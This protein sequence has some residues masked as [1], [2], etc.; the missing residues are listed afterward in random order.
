MTR[1][2]TQL[3][4]TFQLHTSHGPVQLVDYRGKQKV[5]MY[6]MREFNCPMCTKV[7]LH[8][9]RMHPELQAHNIQVLVLGGGDEKAAHTL[10]KRFDLPF[11]VAADPNRNIYRAYSLEKTLGLLQWNGT[12]LVDLD[13]KIVYQRVS[14]RPGGSFD[15]A[16]LKAHW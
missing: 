8:L 3:A 5:L 11:P 16:E 2:L 12:V 13:G 10:Q 6:F 9:K 14:Q 4:P 15:E 1:T 7:V